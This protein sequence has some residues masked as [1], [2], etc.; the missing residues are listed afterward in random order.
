[1]VANAV[2]GGEDLQFQ[3][4]STFGA[5]LMMLDNVSRGNLLVVQGELYGDPLPRHGGSGKRLYRSSA[6]IF[7]YHYILKIII[8]KYKIDR[9]MRKRNK[10]LNIDAHI[11][12]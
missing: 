2:R 4:E 1:M 10:N 7:N 6:V 3:V 5:S 9:K 12:M 11:V 8:L